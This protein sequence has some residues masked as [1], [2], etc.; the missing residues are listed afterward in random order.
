[1][2]RYT[3]D[4]FLLIFLSDLDVASIWLQL[5]GGDLTEDLFVNGEEHLETALLDVIVPAGQKVIVITNI[6]KTTVLGTDQR[7]HTSSKLVL[8]FV[9]K[10]RNCSETKCDDNN[11]YSQKIN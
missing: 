2:W 8:G 11:Y 3:P 7:A 5:M 9:I 10:D 1:M 4:V 6:V